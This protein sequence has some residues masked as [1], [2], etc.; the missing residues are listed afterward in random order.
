MTAIL[1]TFVITGL[2]TFVITF[3]LKDLDGPLKMFDHIRVWLHVYTHKFNDQTGEWY[4]LYGAGFFATLFECF[5]CLST[6]VSGFVCLITVIAF[7]QPWYFW[8]YEV[9]ASIALAGVVYII[10]N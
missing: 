2:C 7:S 8:P 6:W 10:K 1:T 5:W 3:F 4:N 9:L